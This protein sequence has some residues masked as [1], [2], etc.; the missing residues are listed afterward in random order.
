M[1]ASTLYFNL[2]CGRTPGRYGNS[3]RASGVLRAAV[4]R[5]PARVALRATN[6]QPKSLPVYHYILWHSSAAR[7]VD[8]VRRQRRHKS[9]AYSHLS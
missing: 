8:A 6:V 4:G 3:R 7:L 9:N 2:I 1:A 5:H